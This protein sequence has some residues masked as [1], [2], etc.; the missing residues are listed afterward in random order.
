[1]LGLFLN[2][3]TLFWGRGL[4]L[5]PELIGLARLAGHWASGSLLRTGIVGV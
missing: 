3:F 2:H 4:S 1:M 5:N